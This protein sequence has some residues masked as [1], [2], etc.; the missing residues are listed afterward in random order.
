MQVKNIIN[1]DVIKVYPSTP[2]E[3]LIILF[4]NFHT[5]P[6]VPVVDEKDKL[7]GKVS[8]TNLLDIFQPYTETTK[9][10][11]QAAPFVNEEQFYDIF[12]T[13]ITPELRALLVVADLM[14][15]RVISIR[16]SIDVKQAYEIMK[17][18]ELEHIPVVTENTTLAG[19]LGM[20][21][22]VRFL[23]NRIE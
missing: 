6:M 21:D 23:F 14:D 16:D 7:T 9:R 18:H 2:L 4:S 12:K 1:K 11:L 5:F 10:L 8:F 20:F 15:S 19:I 3:K 13:Q 17:E 22:I